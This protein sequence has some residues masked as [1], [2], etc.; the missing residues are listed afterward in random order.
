MYMLMDMDNV[1]LSLLD[2]ELYRVESVD[3]VKSVHVDGYCYEGG[4]GGGFVLVQAVGC[5]VGL[6][7]LSSYEDVFDACK[8][9]SCYVSA[10]DVRSYYDGASRL[11]ILSVCDGTPDGLYVNSR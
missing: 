9:S 7:M 10:D 4:D 2:C 6:D 3:G 8:Q 1:F 5:Y 11:P